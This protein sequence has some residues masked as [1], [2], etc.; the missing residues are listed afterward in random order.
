MLPQECGF[1]N[2]VKESTPCLFGK[3]GVDPVK[4]T[5]SQSKITRF[6]L[7]GL[8]EIKIYCNIY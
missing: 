8:T 5:A 7:T 2:L 6:Y 1:V 4:Q 3:T